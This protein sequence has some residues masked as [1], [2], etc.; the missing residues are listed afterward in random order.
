MIIL[1]KSMDIVDFYEEVV[2]ALLNQLF[3]FDHGQSEKALSWI[4]H[5][6]ITSGMY[7]PVGCG[8]SYI[9]L[10]PEVQSK[11]ACVNVKNQDNACLA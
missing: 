11:K 10:P 6:R 5:L 9:P 7:D 2:R 4:H 1:N 8:L 3:N